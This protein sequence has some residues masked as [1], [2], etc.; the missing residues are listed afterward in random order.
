MFGIPWSRYYLILVNHFTKYIWF[1]HMEAKSCVSTTFFQF[2]Y[3]VET[4]FQ[5]KFIIIFSYNDGEFVA[6]KNILYME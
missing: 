1:Y 5:S 6:L 3:L 2:K 4:L